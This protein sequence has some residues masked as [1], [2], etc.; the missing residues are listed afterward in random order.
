MK[1][2]GGL[3]IIVAVTGFLCGLVVVGVKFLADLLEALSYNERK[4]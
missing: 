4:D 2:L 1:V 3:L